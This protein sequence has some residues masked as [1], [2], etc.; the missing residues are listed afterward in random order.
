MGNKQITYSRP[1]SEK[2]DGETCIYRSHLLPEGD[3]LVDKIHGDIV[4]LKSCFLRSFKL[5]S[6]NPFL[7]TRE[8]HEEKVVNEE[9]KETTTKVVFGK[10]MYMTYGQVYEYSNSLA[11]SIIELDLCP[12]R[13]LDNRDI[14]IMGIYS[15]NREEWCLTDVACTL[16][17]ITSVPLY[18]TLGEQS[19]KFI[20]NETE[21]EILVCGEEK[22]APICKLKQ[23][24]AI[25]TLKNLMIYEEI[26][27]A[28]EKLCKDADLKVYNQLKLAE[29]GEK[30][31]VELDTPTPDSIFTICYTSGT[32]GD[33]KGV[34]STHRNMIATIGGVIIVGV[35][36]TPK[37]VHYSY[38]PLAH[39]FERMM[40]LCMLNGGGRIGYYQGDITKIKEDLAALKPTIFPSVPRLLNRFYDLMMAGI[41]Q[42][43]GFKRTLINW[44]ISSKTSTVD[45]TGQFKHGLYDRLV[46]KKF[47]EILGGR[48]RLMITGNCS[49]FKFKFFNIQWDT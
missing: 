44:G 23:S 18:D 21:M 42:Q 33:P 29:D 24:G 1:V 31:E 41:N 2:K 20:I 16:A 11:K 32:T 12:L 30:V 45:K 49:F 34:L 19:I 43:K 22:V 27:P 9:T 25:P 5:N 46:F 3:E 38:L 37:D 17:N 47:K 13:K 7:G 26:T 36:L 39:I 8:K 40:H 10:Y 4:D 28:I 6:K 14:R 35:D 15:K 48:V